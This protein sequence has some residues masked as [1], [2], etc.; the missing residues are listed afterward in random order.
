MVS[1]GV[2]MCLQF[3][4]AGETLLTP[5]AAL[6]H[7]YRRSRSLWMK[8]RISSHYNCGQIGRLWLGAIR[9]VADRGATKRH[10]L[11]YADVEVYG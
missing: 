9:L 2:L 10:P 3:S 8:Q 4:S 6:R 11:Y 5:R 7:Y 1:L